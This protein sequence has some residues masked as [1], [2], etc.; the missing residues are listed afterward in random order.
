MNNSSPFNRGNEYVEQCRIYYLNNGKSKGTATDEEAERIVNILHD[1]DMT[2][3]QLRVANADAHNKVSELQAEL[4]LLKARQEANDTTYDHLL[5][6]SQRLGT[7]QLEENLKRERQAAQAIAQ[8]DAALIAKYEKEIER[9][10]DIHTA[11]ASLISECADRVAELMRVI[12]EKNKALESKSQALEASQKQNDVLADRLSKQ[13][14]LLIKNEALHQ[15]NA[16]SSF[17][18]AILPPP[19]PALENPARPETHWSHPTPTHASY[20]TASTRGHGGGAHL[21][22][23]GR[24]AGPSGPAPPP[25][26]NEV[27]GLTD[28]IRPAPKLGAP[29]MSSGADGHAN[30]TTRTQPPMHS[31]SPPAAGGQGGSG[32]P[33]RKD[34]RR[35]DVRTAASI[36]TA[37]DDWHGGAS[38]QGT[39]ILGRSVQFSL[40]SPAAPSQV[41]MSTFDSR[42]DASIDIENKPKS[43]L[44]RELQACKNEVETLKGENATLRDS[45]AADRALIKT[46][47]KTLEHVRASAEEITLLEAEE[48]ARLEAELDRVTTE[49]D[50]WA[51]TAKKFETQIELMK[52]GQHGMY[53]GMDRGHMLSVS[54]GQHRGTSPSPHGK[55]RSSSPSRGI[56]PTR[57][58]RGA[59]ESLHDRQGR[60]KTPRSRSPTAKAGEMPVAESA[61]IEMYRS[62]PIGSLLDL[63]YCCAVWNES[64][65]FYYR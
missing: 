15:S 51:S 22:H 18:R 29:F 62:V 44:Y 11:D 36:S 56:S 57:S 40:D 52:Y 30:G 48:I 20:A 5:H 4:A 65:Q 8:H 42:Y 7:L 6:K 3:E 55:G 10:S 2:Y 17:A 26:G 53:S 63:L 39:P 37:R 1:R 50:K 38:S 41:G 34:P 43:V 59:A 21:D 16:I 12:E 46:Q 45:L 32:I 27:V 19:V 14:V 60:G 47:E 61:I 25:T 24:Y 23:R 64:R 58:R 13:E 49:R 28:S 54:G 35:E 9:L 31:V 33:V